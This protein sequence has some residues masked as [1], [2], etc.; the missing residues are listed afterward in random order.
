MASFDSY[1]DNDFDRSSSSLSPPPQHPAT[2]STVSFPFA[3]TSPLVSK[4][5]GK[6]LPTAASAAAATNGHNASS[7][8]TKKQAAVVAAENNNTNHEPTKKP[9]LWRLREA[10][11]AVLDERRQ[12]D[13][14]LDSGAKDTMLYLSGDFDVDAAMEVLRTPHH[15]NMIGK[16]FK[17]AAK[18]L[19]QAM[20]QTQQSSSKLAAADNDDDDDDDPYGRS[21]PI[22]HLPAVLQV[23]QRV[24]DA[25]TAALQRSFEN[26]EWSKKVSTHSMF[27]QEES[28]DKRRL[29]EYPNGWNMDSAFLLLNPIV[30]PE[31]IQTISLYLI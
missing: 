16:A 7:T 22:P 1:Y 3:K 5:R 25:R 27:H 8:K 18:A 23:R 19:L 15:E 11:Q 14:L 9:Q 6:V 30:V 28:E 13:L 10:A 31:W 12:L 17:M 4:S 26:K 2:A 20:R 24:L 29:L 21:K